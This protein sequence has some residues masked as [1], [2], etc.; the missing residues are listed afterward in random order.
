MKESFA[1]EYVRLRIEKDDNQRE[2]KKKQKM[3]EENMKKQKAFAKQQ[4]MIRK[5][6]DLKIKWRDGT[7]TEEEKQ[8]VENL[9]S[10]IEDM[11]T[12]NSLSEELGM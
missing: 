12:I 3:E 9:I 8:P 4:Y 6:E 7:L 10:Q 1:A 2:E 5:F 11:K